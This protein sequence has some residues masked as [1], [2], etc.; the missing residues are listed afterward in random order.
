MFDQPQFSSPNQHL[1]APTDGALNWN[2]PPDILNFGS[3]GASTTQGNF[4]SSLLAPVDLQLLLSDANTLLLPSPNDGVNYLYSPDLSNPSSQS[5]ASSLSPPSD[6]IDLSWLNSFLPSPSPVPYNQTSSTMTIP[7][8]FVSESGA[9]KYEPAINSG[10]H[11]MYDVFGSMTT[12]A[13]PASPPSNSPTPSS[14][15]STASSRSSSP[16]SLPPSVT[17]I[18]SSCQTLGISPSNLLTDLGSIP[19]PTKSGRNIAPKIYSCP[20]E[21]CNHTFTRLFNL[22]AHAKTHDPSRN[23]PFQCTECDKSFCRQHD[24]DRHATVHSKV[25]AFN[26]SYCLRPFTRIDAKNR[27]ER[28]KCHVV[29]AIRGEPKVA[30]AVLAA[31]VANHA[32]GPES[33]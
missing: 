18:L 24:L 5:A 23:R 22:R 1:F 20:V 10:H 30:A 8:I 11:S 7:D 15:H 2:L 19:A 29:K 3:T 25:R 6:P 4:D 17:D 21:G 32:K 12:N 16:E 31:V 26:C 13:F 9:V 27:H 33:G 28:D 14:P